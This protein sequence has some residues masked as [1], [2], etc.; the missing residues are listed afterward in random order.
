MKLYLRH[1]PESEHFGIIPHDPENWV[2]YET[3]LNNQINLKENL[4]WRE[5]QDL[6]KLILRGDLW[7]NFPAHGYTLVG[8]EFKP[9]DED[10]RLDIL[11]LRDDGALLPCELKIGGTYLDTHGQLI[12]Y[13]SDLTFQKI[14]LKYLQET[15]KKHLE[16]ITNDATRKMLSEKFNKFIEDNIITDRFIRV[17]P[18][19]G[20]I[21]D[22][23]FKP[24]IL[25]TVRYLNDY[26]GFAIKMIRIDTYVDPMWKNDWEEYRMRIE[27]VDIT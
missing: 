5:V 24:Q 7:D 18:K 15:N 6:Q 20:L 25:K 2:E 12:R 11:Y 10:Q 16:T 8:A 21:I 19:T 14:D 4:G 23:G 1:F 26:C 3:P 13:I 17:L 9:G 27:L 22:E